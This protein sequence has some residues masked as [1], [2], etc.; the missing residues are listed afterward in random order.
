MIPS[1]LPVTII[2]FPL[3]APQILCKL[4]YSNAL[5]NMQSSLEHLKTIVYSKL[6]QQT[7]YIMGNSKVENVTP[8]L[9]DL[10]FQ[11]HYLFF[12]R[13]ESKRRRTKSYEQVRNQT[14]N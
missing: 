11:F 7:E 12:T 14:T 4:L 2:V 13:N 3:F 9:S 5:G 8:L 1:P 10:S 6:G